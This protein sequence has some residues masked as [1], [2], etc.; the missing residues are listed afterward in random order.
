MYL[1]SSKTY[2][3]IWDSRVITIKCSTYVDIMLS[4]ILYL[5]RA[6]VRNTTSKSVC[7]IE[8]YIASQHEQNKPLKIILQAPIYQIRNAQFVVAMRHQSNTIEITILKS[9]L[10]I[11]YLVKLKQVV[12]KS[13][14]PS[15]SSAVICVVC[16]TADE[17]RSFVI[18]LSL[19]QHCTLYPNPQRMQSRAEQWQSYWQLNTLY[20]LYCVEILRRK[21]F[22]L[23]QTLSKTFCEVKQAGITPTNEVLKY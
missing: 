18:V 21:A 8:N 10:V 7:C 5:H 9:Q 23:K 3:P 13:P 16:S 17:T 22:V 19:G 4:Q 1:H 15:C 2:T 11:S 12:L 6:G 14:E 20:F